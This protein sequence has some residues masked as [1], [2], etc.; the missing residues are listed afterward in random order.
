[1][2]DVALDSLFSQQNN[3]PT[4]STP[5]T[6][7]RQLPRARSLCRIPFLGTGNATAWY[8]LRPQHPSMTFFLSG[9]I[10]W[11]FS[12]FLECLLLLVQPHHARSFYGHLQLSVLPSC[13]LVVWIWGN[14]YLFFR[15]VGI[16]WYCSFA[17]LAVLGK[18][19]VYS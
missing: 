6:W 15:D 19:K 16:I 2:F 14:H 3:G 13:Y 9:G 17:S 8:L 18:L 7:R 4:K 12:N 11:E 10:F 5:T 1:M